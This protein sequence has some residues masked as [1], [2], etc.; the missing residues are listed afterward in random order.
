MAKKTTKKVDY[1]KVEKTKVMEIIKEAL[2]AAGYTTIDG[3]DCGFTSGTLV[4]QGDK[5]DIQI[6]PI[7][8]K[9]GVDRYDVLEEEVEE[10]ENIQETNEEGD[11]Q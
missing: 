1:K 10:E 2:E 11:Q 8:P 7:T 9:A 4:A 3:I 6:K 5:C